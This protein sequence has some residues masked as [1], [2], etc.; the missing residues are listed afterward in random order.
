VR[1]PLDSED[2]RA[3]AGALTVLGTSVERRSNEWRLR[4]GPA[5]DRSPRLRIDCGESGT[6]LRF[7][8]ALAALDHRPAI[9]TGAPRLSER[10]IEDLLQALRALGA[11]AQRPGSAGL[12]ITVRG[13]IHSGR[14]SLNASRSSQFASALLLV[15][16]HLAGDS[17]LT[18]E[19]PLVSQPYIESTVAVLDQQGIRLTRHGRRFRIAGSQRTRRRGFV[20]PGDA[21]SAAYLW[22]AAAVSGGSVR[23]RGVPTAWPQ[24]DRAIL[25]LL[26]SWGARVTRH[27]DGATVS[28][29]RRLPFRIDLTDAPD[30]YPLAGVLA[31]ITPGRSRIEGAAHAT[32]KESDRRE[33][34]AAL[35]RQLGAAPRATARSLEIRGTS[36]PRAIRAP[37]MRDHRMVMSAAVG[38]LAADGPSIVGDRDAVAKSFPGFW[39]VLSSL[40]GGSVSA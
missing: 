30:L 4:P 29:D 9:L 8:S 11:K 26:E 7:A 16:P 19:G 6:T 21:S 36:H 10:P 40:L 20:V 2:T 22:A 31:A 39:E 17:V 14:V 18:L 5:T 27:Q 13:P 35:A 24:A 37:A 23:V 38:A 34:T 3:T 15:L 33:E 28:A 32:L 12:P 25:G 1:N